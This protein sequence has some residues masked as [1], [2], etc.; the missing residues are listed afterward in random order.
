[1]VNI[2]RVKARW[3][4]FSGAP[5]YTVMHFRD[6]DTGDGPG[7]DPTAASAQAASDRMRAFLGAFPELLPITVRIDLDPNVDILEDSTGTMV[8]SL[9][10]TP[11]A[12]LSG[13][14]GGNYSAAI[15]AV[16]N[17]STGSIRAGR[18]VRGRSF[19]VPLSSTAFFTDGT[20]S[21]SALTTLQAAANILV[22]RTNTPDL[23]VYARPT[24]AGAADGQ[25]VVATGARV[26]DMGAVLRSRRD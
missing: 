25:W 12:Q 19:L 26:P 2:M 6:F 10:V 3:T 23:G 14:S 18:R 11:G 5:G 13:S 4:G 7:V 24:L 20:L 17:W 1:M 21:A 15:G 9:T 16:V 8:D 22:D